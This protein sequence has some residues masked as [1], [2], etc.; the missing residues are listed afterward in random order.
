MKNLYKYVTTTEP[1]N[2]LKSKELRPH[3]KKTQYQQP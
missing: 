3:T 1:M 2:T